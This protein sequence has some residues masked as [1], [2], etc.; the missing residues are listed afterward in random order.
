PHEFEWEKAARGSQGNSFAWGETD[1][2]TARAQVGHYEPQAATVPVGSYARGQ[3]PYGVYDMGGN[4]REWIDDWYDEEHVVLR[5]AAWYDPP[6]YSLA[7]ARL[8]H[9]PHSAGE[10]RGFRCVFE[11]SLPMNWGQ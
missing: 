5:G 4:V 7:Y 6:V 2:F 1:D 11:D 9:E 10:G 8:S 3:S